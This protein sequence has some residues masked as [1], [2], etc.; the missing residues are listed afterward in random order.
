MAQ[1]PRERPGVYRNFTNPFL[2]RLSD[3][4]LRRVRVAARK[5]SKSVSDFMRDG[6]MAHTNTV[7]EEELAK[8]RVQAEVAERTFVPRNLHSSRGLGLAPVPVA[9][10]VPLPPPAPPTIVVQVPSPAPAAP[11]D[12]VGVLVDYVLAARDSADAE[13]RKEVAL[14]VVTASANREDHLRLAK[15]LDE[16]LAKRAPQPEPRRS[17][18]SLL[19]GLGSARK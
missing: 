19:G 8:S 2:L 5:Q 9:P 14:Q 17:V 11:R 4:Q 7:T 10:E 13:K 6:V 18:W 3:D 1:P 12:E 16:A 15:A